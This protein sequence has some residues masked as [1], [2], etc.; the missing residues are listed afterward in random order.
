MSSDVFLYSPPV[1]LGIGFAGN[2]IRNSL[3]QIDGIRLNDALININGSNVDPYEFSIWS[4]AVEHN[5]WKSHPLLRNSFPPP[6]KVSQRN[7]LLI[8]NGV[9]DF[10]LLAARHSVGYTYWDNNYL[11]QQF[12]RSR[13]DRQ[14]EIWVPSGYGYD[15]ISSIVGGNRVRRS[16]LPFNSSIFTPYSRDNTDGVFTF[17]HI[18][19]P[20]IKSNYMA[21]VRAFRK[22]FK[23]LSNY[24]LILKSYG[25]AKYDDNS[26]YPNAIDMMEDHSLYS[27]PQIQVVNK[28]LDDVEINSLYDLAD[29]VVHPSFGEGWGLT[30]FNAIGKGVPTICIDKTGCAEYSHCSLPLPARLATDHNL[31]KF[32]GLPMASIADDDL[33]DRMKWATDNYKTIVEVT[34]IGSEYVR[35]HF[36]EE[37]F[38]NHISS[39]VHNII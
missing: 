4:S 34:R 5:D 30:P 28:Y 20:V 35:T 33:C 8:N 17:L 29:C 15:F 24:K 22:L 39:L 3:G 12:S 26:K 38:K 13:L 2:S 23:G 36:S 37:N 18:G 14:D 1:S 16:F 32:A 31:D 19:Y 7:G 11:N 9:P 27:D 6:I 21:V 25:L 10:F